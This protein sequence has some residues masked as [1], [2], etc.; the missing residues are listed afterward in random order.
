MQYSGVDV[1]THP[2]APGFDGRAFAAYMLR[3]QSLEALR[4]QGGLLADE[5]HSL[6]TDLQEMV[7]TNYTNFIGAAQLVSDLKSNVDGIHQDLEKLEESVGGLKSVHDGIWNQVSAGQEEVA[8]LA[9]LDRTLKKIRLLV[10][11]PPRLRR[12]VRQGDI[13]T[14][15]RLWARGDA[16][17]RRHERRVT[18][19][20]GVR[21][22]CAKPLGEM[23]HALTSVIAGG[24]RSPISG[25]AVC[26]ANEEVVNAVGLYK[27]LHGA[28]EGAERARHDAELRRLLLRAVDAELDEALSVG[29]SDADRN[30]LALMQLRRPDAEPQAADHGLSSALPAFQRAAALAESGL[31][32]C[33]DSAAAAAAGS[34]A[35]LEPCAVACVRAAVARASDA[36]LLRVER[37][38]E[39]AARRRSASRRR[40][41]V[42]PSGP[43]VRELAEDAAAAAAAD[44]RHASAAALRLLQAA[45]PQRA[46]VL[47]TE[48]MADLTTELVERLADEGDAGSLD[49]G[50]ERRS[51]SLTRAT[52]DLQRSRSRPRRDSAAEETVRRRALAALPRCAFAAAITGSPMVQLVRA[53]VGADARSRFAAVS[54]RLCARVAELEG[55]SIAARVRSGL[56]AAVAAGHRSSAAPSI[57][58]VGTLRAL[59]AAD[60]G[61][62]DSLSPPAPLGEGEA[63]DPARISNTALWQALYTLRECVRLSTLTAGA[64]RQ[65]QIDVAVLT[66]RLGEA[67][68]APPSQAMQC[69][70]A[71]DA[72]LDAR[73]VEPAGSWRLPSDDLAAA[74]ATRAPDTVAPLLAEASEVR[75]DLVGWQRHELI[76]RGSFGSVFVAQL[77]SGERRAVKTV[78]LGSD[79]SPE[80][81]RCIAAEIEV[82]AD[83]RHENIVEY[84]GCMYDVG[85]NEILIFMEYV[86]CGSFGLLVRRLRDHGM[87]LG[88]VAAACFLG[89][90]LQGVVF[91]HANDVIHRDLKGDNILLTRGG[92]AKIADFG[93]CKRLVASLAT[94][95]TG[96]P[97]W[98]APEV[99]AAGANA[100]YSCSADVWSFGIV[101]CEFLSGAPPWPK[102]DSVV[103]AM[104]T[105]AR[106]AEPLPPLCPSRASA[107][108]TDLMR[109]C[110]SPDVSHRWT[111]AMLQRH[112]WFGAATDEE[113]REAVED[114]AVKYAEIRDADRA[115]S[116]GSETLWRS[117]YLSS[118]ETP[119]TPPDFD[120]A[121]D[122]AGD[123]PPPEPLR[124]G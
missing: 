29:E 68:G 123:T 2:D 41:T 116:P 49:A 82:L 64:A 7:Y 59:A 62:Y 94:T 71:V 33:G 30:H 106:W 16:L 50:Y 53:R 60:A 58:S 87:V 81:A 23:E 96:T 37:Q 28:C 102:F 61:A 10:D 40:G 77:P 85:S 13:G 11:L 92:C 112:P 76:G 3:T 121:L 21:A 36:V 89:Q 4:E 108:A 52:S 72:E 34:S 80:Q 104:Y 67:V 31:R 78:V 46:D 74:A 65:L 12:C 88:E 120:V 5:T 8:Q 35:H 26:P 118:F 54:A 119:I 25:D 47:L 14:A 24:L 93:A 70:A 115:D 48:V 57:L 1:E 22:A 114:I 111:A 124:V 90:V 117:T 17:L 103:Q 27:E 51:S 98:M 86:E 63:A 32:L 95:A 100:S 18:A 44:I 91:L 55:H 69:L 6:D 79:M 75:S 9:G 97:L 101:C 19:L 45:V 15:V 113:K 107:E 73:C 42:S 56:A 84:V 43:S 99:I 38:V 20:G 110:L 39:P 105:I 109:R 83:V 122:Y 66:A